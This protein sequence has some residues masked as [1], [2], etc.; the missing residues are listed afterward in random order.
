MIALRAAVAQAFP[1]AAGELGM[2]SAAWLFVNEA[3]SE[4][5]AALVEA[6]RDWLGRDFPVLD[7]V[8]AQWLAGERHPKVDPGPVVAL[9]G[10]ATRLVV[11]GLEAAF[12]DTLVPRLG[13]TRAAILRTDE[14]GA[15]WDRVLANYD[16]KLE[17]T[18]LSSFQTLGGNRSV[19]LTFAY[20]VREPITHV[21]A[22]WL[23]VTGADVRTQFRTL[24]AW[25]VLR[26]EM[27]VYPRWLVETRTSD[28]SQ[29]V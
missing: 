18:D 17:A 16:G 28:F 25:D 13:A 7:A 4:G 5:G 27:Y 6:V 19:L 11:V 20:G 3:A 2:C 22:M 1:V 10:G 29:I 15:D 9:L 24:I 12:L 26:A 14:L 8:A 23:R 21:S